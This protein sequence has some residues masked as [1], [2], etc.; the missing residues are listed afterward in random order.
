MDIKQ[1]K[2]LNEPTEWTLENDVLQV[3][4]NNN[5]DFWRETHYGFTR[6][7]G[8]V[9]GVEVRGDFTLQLCIEGAFEQLYDQ[10]GLMIEQGPRQWCKAGIEFSDGQFLMSS[11]LTNGQSD[12][13]TGAFQGNPEKF[14]M[15]ATLENGVLRLQYSRDAITWPLIRLCPFPPAQR[16]FVG[17]MCCTPERE[18]L[19]I[20]FSEFRLTKP[21]GKAL[22]DL[23]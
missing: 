17:A 1:G 7:S 11:V 22:H 9:F 4:T 12:W 10:A 16:R 6:H 21:L 14:W 20:R 23:S 8:H 18:G 3:T 13:A 2:W 15:R 19:K 5:T